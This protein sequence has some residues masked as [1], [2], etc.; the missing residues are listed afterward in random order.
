MLTTPAQIL[1]LTLIV[2]RPGI[3]LRE[4]QEELFSILQL[5]IDTSTICRFLQAS[6]CTRQKLCLVALQ[7]DQ[8]LRQQYM[9]DI[10]VY[11]PDVF[12]F[13]DE[14]GADQRD[15]VR[16]YGY[17]LRGSPIKKQALLV[18]GERT[19]AVA[20]MSTKGILDV[21][22]TKGTTNGDT[23]YKFILANLLPHLQ[24]FNGI[25]PHSVLI[26]D[27]C[28]IHH[29]QEIVDIIEDTGALLHFLPPYSPD[30]NPIE[31]AFSKVKSGIKGLESSMGG[32]DIDC[33]ILAAFASI[34]QHDCQQW[35]SHSLNTV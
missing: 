28:S 8:F 1:I 30:L 7:R 14:T 21:Q 33:I 31:M 5:E 22:I 26:M 18:R 15:V 25:N 4:I 6:G 11:D 32:F 13:L 34:S 2:K 12:I 17:S 10:S 29:V 35:I 9:S 3:Y 27:N 16:K 24:P 19:S 20:I 23:F